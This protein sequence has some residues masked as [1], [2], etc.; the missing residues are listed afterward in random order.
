MSIL[1]SLK[2]TRIGL[3]DTMIEFI[4]H[5]IGIGIGIFSGFVAALMFVVAILISLY[6]MVRK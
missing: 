3:E 2:L 5:G 1:P 6:W 4:I